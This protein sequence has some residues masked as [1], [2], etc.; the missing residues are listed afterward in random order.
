MK[1]NIW[2]LQE[3]K[4]KFSEVVDICSIPQIITKRGEKTAVVISYD[5]FCKLNKSK[6]N[7]GQFLKSSP[8]LDDLDLNKDNSTYIRD[9]DL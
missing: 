6:K 8:L 7:V 2:Q 9:I 4:S 1:N 5:L 3:A